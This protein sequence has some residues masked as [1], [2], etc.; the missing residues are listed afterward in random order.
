M[1]TDASF[2][3]VYVCL[4]VYKLY[5]QMYVYVYIFV[6]IYICINIYVHTGYNLVTADLC[7]DTISNLIKDA[8]IGLTYPD[9]FQAFQDVGHGTT[10]FAL[11]HH[12]SPCFLVL[13][14]W[15]SP[16]FGEVSAA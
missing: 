4:S 2:G 3:H 11:F 9:T 13:V 15:L 16:A 10:G 12:V 14:S 6:Y 1:T 8:E 5:M 7:C